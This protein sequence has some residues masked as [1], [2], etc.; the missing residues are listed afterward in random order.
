MTP[1]FNLKSREK[2]AVQ[3]S[4]DGAICLCQSL[5]EELADENPF[6]L[7]KEKVRNGYNPKPQMAR[8]VNI[9]VR[10]AK[11]DFDQIRQKTKSVNDDLIRILGSMQVSLK[12]TDVN[13]Y[14]PEFSAKL[15][16][17][18]SR[19]VS[20]RRSWNYRFH[21]TIIVL[22]L[23]RPLGENENGRTALLEDGTIGRAYEFLLDLFLP[24]DR[25]EET[26][27]ALQDVCQSKWQKRYG[28]RRVAFLCFVHII[29]AIYA[30]HA[31]RLRKLGGLVLGITELKKAF[32]KLW[33]A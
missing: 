8:V 23:F 20:V 16:E 27:T 13:D 31:V 29:T 14:T 25:A 22:R 18:R 10:F 5:Q 2:K 17:I 3:E 11:W 7:D 4:V 12:K 21:F 26:S 24:L 9:I 15:E 28:P 33:G 32:S 19:L 30:H 6:L 1:G